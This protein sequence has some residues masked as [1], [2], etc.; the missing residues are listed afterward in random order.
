MLCVS[1]VQAEVPDEVQLS[2]WSS[3]YIMSGPFLSS[4]PINMKRL[5]GEAETRTCE[6]EADEDV[7]SQP[8]LARKTRT[9]A[10]SRVPK[11]IQYTH[12]TSA[13]VSF[14]SMQMAGSLS[15]SVHETEK[16][17]NRQWKEA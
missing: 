11:L 2:L 12:T 7:K 13:S 16:A 14:C 6:L 1:E 10:E 4:T 17:E 15:R 5:K 3:E 9:L 8:M